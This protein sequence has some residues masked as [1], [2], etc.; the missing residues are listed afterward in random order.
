MGNRLY[1]FG[2]FVWPALRYFEPEWFTPGLQYIEIRTTK[3]F[4]EW[5]L[6]TR[7]LFSILS[8]ILL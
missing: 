3:G 8:Q 4:G 2:R 5:K 7:L 1:I 6:L